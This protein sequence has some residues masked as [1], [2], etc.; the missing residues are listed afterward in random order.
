MRKKGKDMEFKSMEE[1]REYWEQ[2]GPLAKGIRAKV[3]EPIENDKRASFLSVRLS[4]R[5]LTQLRD[6]AAKYN[7]GPSTFVR[8]I[9]INLLSYTHKTTKVPTVDDVAKHL[10][11]AMPAELADKCDNLYKSVTVGDNANPTMLIMTQAQLQEAQEIGKR[12]V[13]YIIHS[14]N[15]NA[16]LI[17][18][19]DENYNKIKSARMS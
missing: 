15:P 12:L 16:K 3:S 17:T 4:G 11:G 13:F 6:L 5:E 19:E 10:F 18:P 9:V 2:R 8:N 14:L 1:E 7:S